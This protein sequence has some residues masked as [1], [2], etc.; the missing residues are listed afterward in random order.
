MKIKCE[1]GKFKN[2]GFI[3]AFTAVD[4]VM[5]DRNYVVAVILTSENKLIY[6]SLD[7]IEIKDE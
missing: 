1:Y 7:E 6:M 3:L 2:K 5:R 4:N